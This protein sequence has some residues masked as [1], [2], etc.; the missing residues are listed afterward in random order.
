[1]KK[2]QLMGWLVGVPVVVLLLML[3]IVLYEPKKEGIS[4]AEVAKAVVLAVCSPDELEAWRK[5]EASSRFAA[6]SQSQWYVPYFDYLYANGYLSEE[7]TP[8]TG[9]AAEG[10]LT[11][12]EARGIAEAVDPALVSLIGSGRQDA[13]RAYP[14][15][16]W[17]LFYD[18]LLN[19]ADP[20][21]QVQRCTVQIYGT[22]ETVPQAAAWTAYTNLGRVDFAGLSLDTYVDHELTVL[23]RDQALI[24]IVEDKGGKLTCR[25][26][27]LVDGDADGL[28]VCLGDLRR[29][30]PFGKASKKTEELLSN[31]ADLEMED[32]KITKV[33]L[34]KERIDGRILSVQ[35]EAIEVEGYGLVALDEEFRVFKTYGN[36]E[37]QSLS[38]IL[39]GYDNQELVVARGKLC[40]VLTVRE[41][42]AE[43]IRVLLM[44]QG[45]S[46]VYHESVSL[47]CDGAL[48]LAQG[49]TTDT[50][51]GGEEL[52]FTPGDERLKEGRLILTPE[53]GGEIRVTSLSRSQ[54]IPSY[55][56]RLELLDTE[57]GLVLVNELYL[58][59]YLKK[60]IPSEMPASYEKEAL[61]AQ[62]VCARTYAYVQL[63]SNSYAAY[64]AH[65]DDSTNF[66]VYNNVDSDRHSSSAVDETCGQL[67][68]YEGEPITAYYF[69]T[70]CGVTTDGSVWG[71]DGSGT[72]Y[73]KSVQLRPGR[74]DTDLTDNDRFAA[75]IKDMDTSAYDS[76]FP[77]F[78]WSAA[79]N[80]DILSAN[81][82]GVGRVESVEVTERGAGGVAKTLLVRGDE[83]ERT[84]RGQNPIRAALGDA[85]LSILRQDGKS[86][87]G[88]N[89]L[90]SGFLTVEETGTDSQG[91]KQ[92]QIY[93]GGYGH[94][95]G[96]SQNGA[97]GMA[98]AGMSYTEILT[99]FYE[100]V[101]LEEK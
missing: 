13:S 23:M 11:Y 100:G 36:V 8:A 16:Y 18:S 71:S 59:D 98:L 32:G 53:D 31:L 86:V 44:N 57:N 48:V 89:S 39:I 37:T 41:F 34:K 33:S 75:F 30:I 69:S 84:I 4:R 76:E 14:E 65:I 7:N 96:M 6:Q 51:V 15:E 90:P 55:G 9:E 87:D 61:K 80:A 77:F 49:E 85:S 101:E 27:W 66:Q 17:W 52:T 54:G 63:Q 5:A 97:Q 46:G 1:M 72:P 42:D 24:H 3:V 28:D 78:R 64:G 35:E 56:G 2:G 91:V 67:L 81:I 62:A 83:G 47:V 21:G 50:V 40:A 70:S 94:G 10:Q 92:Y 93:G 25:N 88:W 43:T 79:T 26:V 38:D 29:R 45:F 22:P 68:V 74:D 20:D 73:L 99:F 82:S 60:V 12:G 58:E 95:A 19:Y